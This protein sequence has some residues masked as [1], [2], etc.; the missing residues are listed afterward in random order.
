MVSCLVIFIFLLIH[1]VNLFSMCQFSSSKEVE[2]LIFMILVVLMVLPLTRIRYDVQVILCI[3][4]ILFLSE[5]I[6][7]SALGLIFKAAC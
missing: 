7:L 2:K 6:E 3:S 1:N 5:I 4:L